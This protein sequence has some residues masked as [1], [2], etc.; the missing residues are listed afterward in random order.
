MVLHAE[1]LKNV[2][3][4]H[5][6]VFE[7]QHAFSIQQSFWS[8][9]IKVRKSIYILDLENVTIHF[10]PIKIINTFSYNGEALLLFH[11]RYMYPV[12][13][14]FILIES[15]Y[16]HSGKKKEFLFF[17]QENV[18]KEMAPYMDK[19]LYIAIHEH[20]PRPMDSQYLDTSL[21]PNYSEAEFDAFWR[22]S[23]QR[24]SVQNFLRQRITNP[25][26]PYPKLS[27]AHTLVLCGDTDEIV[28]R[29]EL[30]KFRDRLKNGYLRA[31]QLINEGVD[32]SI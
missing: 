23:Y 12:I 29:D 16:T 26:L 18:K 24:I 7:D 5:I 28:D 4:T 11:I 13:N 10:F 25:T 8:H 15:W 30:N 20:P 31:I 32:D 3:N 22:E 19:I 21:H 9:Q 1:N 17:E 2:F 27:L 14:E 6:E